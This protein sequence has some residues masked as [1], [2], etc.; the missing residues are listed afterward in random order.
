MNLL[1]STPVVNSTN[2]HSHRNGPPFWRPVF[3]V[4]CKAVLPVPLKERLYIADRTEKTF[5][6]SRANGTR[7]MA[8]SA[9]GVCMHTRKYFCVLGVLLCMATVF[10]GCAEWHNRSVQTP[11]AAEP[12]GRD[13]SGGDAAAATRKS[14]GASATPLAGAE[15]E[16][17]GFSGTQVRDERLQAVEELGAMR[18]YFA[19]NRW[20]LR[21]E[22]QRQL[23]RAAL[24]LA[25]HPGLD[26]RIDGHCDQLGSDAY[27]LALGERRARE[28]YAALVAKG[29]NSS[30][31]KMAT[32]GK[33][34]P[35]FSGMDAQSRSMNRR[36][37]F[38]L[39]QPGL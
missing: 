29:V 10:S 20:E 36:G 27:N 4:P 11:A 9:Y 6:C 39:L 16:R 22:A 18:I 24:L 5:I 34:Y 26:I 28:V 21:Q 12:S 33:H 35:A 7:R 38:V 1:F 23:D 17:S 37:E 2:S 32:F 19:F 3:L 8:V 30:Q 31:L 25:R 15:T 14:Q 13:T